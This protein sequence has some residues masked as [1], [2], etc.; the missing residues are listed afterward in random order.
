MMLGMSQGALADALGITFQQ[1]QKYEKG[2]NR[3]SASKLQESAN[4]LQVPI[5][6]FSRAHRAI[7][8]PS[9]RHGTI[10][11]NFWLQGTG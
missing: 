2:A 8:R 11:P 9:R 4:F 6:F 10:S 3:L 7:V 5:A 1:V